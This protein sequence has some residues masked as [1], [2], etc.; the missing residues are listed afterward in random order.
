MPES[1]IDLAGLRV[2]AEDFLAAVLETTEQPIWVVD[3]DGVIRFANPAAIAALGYERADE[4][5][6]ATATRRS[7]TGTR[8][9]RRS[10]PRS[11]RC[12]VRS[13]P[14]RRSRASWTGSSAATARCSPSPTS[15]SRSRCRTVAARSWPSPTSRIACAPSRCC[16]STTRPWRRSRR[17]CG[18]SRRSSPAGR[19]RRTCSPPSPGRSASV[20][21]L[22]LVAVWRLRAGRDG[23]RGRRLERAAA[24]VPG[25]HAL[26]ARRADDLRHRSWRPAAPRAS[27]TSRSVPGTI[28]DAARDDRDHARPPAPR[29]SSTA[30]C[31]ARCRPTRSDGA[32][33]P[34]DIEDR[35]VEFTEL[36]AA[37][38]STTARQDGARPA[39][40]RAGRAAAGGDARRARRAGRRAV[41]RRHRGGRAAAPGRRRRDDPLRAGRRG[42]RRRELVGR[43]RGR[44]HRGRAAVAARGGE[45]GAADPRGP[46]GS[47]RIDDWKR[48]ARADRRLRPDAARAEL[49]RRKPDPRRGPRVGQPGR[50]LHQRAAPARHRGAHR[51]ASPSSWPRRS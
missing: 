4:L 42:H 9:A 7:T 44:R 39:R 49:V 6:G 35:L 31:G 1:L 23:D 40:G 24:S 2:G 5:S 10:P 51:R 47:A 19:R 20:I 13:R 38:F 30:R 34:D 27:T 29:S 17:R 41:R 11:A 45:P 22:P 3:H 32:P 48:R 46:G 12:C 15:R 37:A 14:A 28:A 50:P 36:V 8:T 21:G 26:A 18:G 25:R 16:A 43:G 33:L